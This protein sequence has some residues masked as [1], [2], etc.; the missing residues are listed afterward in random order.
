MRARRNTLTS[1]TAYAID[2]TNSDIAIG[3]V[4]AN[5]SPICSPANAFRCSHMDDMNKRPRVSVHFLESKTLERKSHL[6]VVR[7]RQRRVYDVNERN[8]VVC[9][10]LQQRVV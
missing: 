5:A 2:A 1:A 3:T 9:Q 4:M 6:F 8:W 7:Q 10:R